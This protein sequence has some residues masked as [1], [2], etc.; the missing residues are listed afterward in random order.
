MVIPLP[1]TNSETL[2]VDVEILNDPTSV[3]YPA[4]SVNL[5]QSG[6]ISIWMYSRD[7]TVPTNEPVIND[8]GIF[9]AKGTAIVDGK[10]IPNSEETFNQLKRNNT[11]VQGD[12]LLFGLEH[13]GDG[14]IF[15]TT[16]TF[17]PLFVHQCSTH[18]VLSTDIGLL[19]KCL[20][21]R[22][23]SD[24][25]QFF[26]VDY[27]YESIENEWGTRVFPEKTMFKDISRA[28]TTT[29]YWFSDY[30]LLSKSV[31][32]D[33]FR[34][35][36]EELYLKDKQLFYDHCFEIIE[37]SI[38]AVFEQL[39]DSKIELLMSGGLDSRLSTVLVNH[40][41]ADYNVSL[42]ATMF[43]PVDHPD[44]VI[45]KRVTDLMDI[46][47][48][49]KTGD[50]KIWKPRS[51]EDYRRG[52]E[53]SWGDWSSNN[54]RTSKIFQERLVISGQDN[55]KR[56]NWAKIFSMNRW[57]AARMSYTSTIP[58][59]SHQIINDMILIYGKHDF[60]KA[61]FE[62][63][64]ELMKRYNPDVLEIPLVGMEIPQHPIP[65]YSSVRESK[66][67]PSIDAEAFFDEELAISL[68]NRLRFN[69]DRIVTIDSI[70]TDKRKKRII[71]DFASLMDESHVAWIRG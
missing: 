58:I 18:T 53:V 71:M 6:N 7:S 62:F 63:A 40:V 8:N 15:T 57:Y 29:R 68:L 32:Y 66:M 65:A 13:N 2:P 44:V 4:K 25:I 43:G 33:L 3:T 10:G 20:T 48:E 38:R 35:D 52:M 14:E 42:Y 51:I 28:L 37:K 21:S 17:C 5:V 67:M 31:Q 56:H 11:Q 47:S 60:H 39:R 19:N 16:M 9:L 41:A 24:V 30:Q 36:L 22:R 50:G 59:L 55:Y 64:Y 49:N 69:G 61:M 23:D 45:G 34:K 70:L 1:S 12:Y 27:I 46:P 54:W 26:D